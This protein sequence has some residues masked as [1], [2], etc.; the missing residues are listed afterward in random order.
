MTIIDADAHVHESDHTWD[1]ILDSDRQFKPLV[2]PQEGAEP[3]VSHWIVDGVLQPH[4]A[5][6]GKA[7]PRSYREL[8]DVPG[9]IRHM[10]ELGIDLQVL[11]PSILTSYSDRPEVEAALWRAYNR[12]IIDA[13][14]GT[15][16]RLRW[17]CRVP[18]TNMDDACSELRFAHEHG[19]C[20]VFLRSI[21]GERLLCDPFFFPLYEE[22]S[23]LDMPI[24][25]HVSIGNSRLFDFYSQPP[26]NGP[27][28]KFKLGIV[29]TA[30]TLLMN[31]IPAQF[32]KLRWGMIEA[33]AE[34]VPYVVRELQKRY[35]RR[36]RTYEGNLLRDNRM[37][38]TCQA[39]DDLPHILKYAGDDTLIIGTDYGHADSATDLQAMSELRMREDVDSKAVDR[40]LDDN[41]RALYGL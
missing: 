1:F 31:D 34:W 5:N 20:G 6:A 39:D 36:G 41:A 21:E 10:D 38:V 22:A 30:H 19:A 23:A 15:N 3:G 2:F 40:I 26:D 27:F 16:G 29:G 8:Q 13:T 25:V 9:R 7:T 33:S 32:P 18:L 17:V 35:A 28:L 24:C 12:W 14:E 4:G 11:Y 37:Y